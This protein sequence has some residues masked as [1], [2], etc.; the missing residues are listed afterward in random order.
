MHY[1]IISQDPPVQL[2]DGLRLG[3]SDIYINTLEC[4]EWLQIAAKAAR[5]LGLVDPFALDDRRAPK[6][7]TNFDY[8]NAPWFDVNVNKAGWDVSE[9]PALPDMASLYPSIPWTAPQRYR[10]E[11]WCEK[12]TMNDV[13]KPWAQGV[14]GA[15]QTGVGEISISACTWAIDRAQR[16]DWKPVR[17]LYVSDFDPAGQSMPVAAARKLEYLLASVLE[18]RDVPDGFSIQLQP[19]CLTADQVRQYQL[20]R[21]P[22]KESER[23]AGRFE[24]RFGAGAVELD[25]LEALYP[26]ELQRIL[27]QAAIDMGWYD[28]DLAYRYNQ[29]RGNVRR[30]VERVTSDIQANFDDDWQA[31]DDDWQAINDDMGQRITDLH[32]KIQAVQNDIASQLDEWIADNW[33]DI[34]ADMPEARE[35]EPITAPM[36]DSNRDYFDQLAYY[37][38]FQGK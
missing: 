19:V 13:L 23:R 9:L 21:T 2:P 10:L 27:T 3:E 24:T 22:I 26:G 25:A 5:Y 37:K 1:W 32:A 7:S 14:G 30:A 11:V 6:E 18:E 16:H 15:V 38:S 34:T 12:S 35:R 31:L 28:T 20:P 36:F 29:W 17:I 8:Y 4:W 33:E